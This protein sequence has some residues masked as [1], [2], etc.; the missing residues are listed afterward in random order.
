MPNFPH[1][2]DEHAA[3]SGIGVVVLAPFGHQVE[4]KAAN[5][6]LIVIGALLDF[7]ETGRVDVQALD[8]NENFVIVNGHGIVNL[9]C[10]LRQNPSRRDD[11]VRAVW[12]A[13][14]LHSYNLPFN[15]SATLAISMQELCQSYNARA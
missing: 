8:I 7:G 2:A 12:T 15:L 4:N 5:S 6:C 3:T 10:R 1:S 14:S 11:P 13:L 9:P